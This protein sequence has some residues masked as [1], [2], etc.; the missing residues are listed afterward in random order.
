MIGHADS[1]CQKTLDV[2]AF[3]APDFPPLL[4][5][6]CTVAAFCDKSA[7]IFRRRLLVILIVEREKIENEEM[8]KT[9]KNDRATTGLQT[10]T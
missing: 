10:E 1:K 5:S 6:V 8:N 4:L 2:L 9:E 3:I 7:C